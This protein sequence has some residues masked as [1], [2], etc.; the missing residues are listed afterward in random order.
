MTLIIKN[1]TSLLNHILTPRRQ[2]D[3]KTRNLD[4]NIKNKNQILTP[5]RNHDVE[6]KEFHVNGNHF[7]TPRRRYDVI[8]R[9]FDDAKKP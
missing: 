3:V 5:R 6:N 8:Y 1:F 4:V 2:Y 9:N 7:T